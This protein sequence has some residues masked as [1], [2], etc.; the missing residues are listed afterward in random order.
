MKCPLP[1]TRVGPKH[2]FPEHYSPK[3]YL[4]E[5]A[6][7][8]AAYV[9]GLGN[10]SRLWDDLTENRRDEAMAGRRQYILI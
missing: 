2:A 7:L 6:L 10:V 9:V 4:V 8:I 3:K 1:L 5:F